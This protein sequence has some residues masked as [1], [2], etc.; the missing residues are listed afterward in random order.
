MSDMFLIFVISENKN[1]INSKKTD[2]QI[3]FY[4]LQIMESYSGYQKLT[5]CRNEL[6]K[7]YSREL[8]YYYFEYFGSG[9]FSF[10][11]NLLF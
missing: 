1:Y 11:N 8:L 2:I 5:T 4:N 6:R 3:G 10:L 7:A 9:C